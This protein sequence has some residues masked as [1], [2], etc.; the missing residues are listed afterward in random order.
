MLLVSLSPKYH[1]KRQ[2]W[3]RTKHQQLVWEQTRQL[4]ASV[5]TRKWQLV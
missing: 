1:S 2:G 3:E 5:L 4:Q